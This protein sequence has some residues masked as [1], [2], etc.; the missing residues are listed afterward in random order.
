MGEIETA[1]PNLFR[2]YALRR[3]VGRGENPL[4]AFDNALIGAGLAQYNLV[5]VSSILAPRSREHSEV[6]WPPGAILF[7]AWS[8]VFTQGDVLP[9]SAAVSVAVPADPDNCG[10]IFEHHGELGKEDCVRL[11]EQYAHRQMAARRYAVADVRSIAAATSDDDPVGEGPH[12]C[13]FACVAL[14]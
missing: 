12:A 5:Q 4:L 3:G 9:L 2:R 14:F 11:C 7:A 1:A 6:Q 10:L 13:A 8:R